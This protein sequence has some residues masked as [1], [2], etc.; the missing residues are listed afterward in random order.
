MSGIYLAEEFENIQYIWKTQ[1]EKDTKLSLLNSFKNGKNNPQ[2]L[3][4]DIFQQLDKCDNSVMLKDPLDIAQ[5]NLAFIMYKINRFSI[6]N[7]LIHDDTLTSEKIEV[8]SLQLFK[9]KNAD[10]GNSFEDFGQIGILVRMVDK[11][12]RILSLTN[13]KRLCIDDEPLID[14]Y[15]DLYNYSILYVLAGN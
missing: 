7:L 13:N 10:Y 1:F 14:C 2:S 8:D 3:K 4:E 11:L 5:L 12:N 9:K 6:W 15:R